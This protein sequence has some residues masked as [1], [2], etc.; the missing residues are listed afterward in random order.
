[1]KFVPFVLAI[2]MVFQPMTVIAAA[3]PNRLDEAISSL[4]LTANQVSWDLRQIQDFQQD[5]FRFP[6]FDQ[7][8]SKPLELPREANSTLSRFESCQNIRDLVVMAARR[9]AHE[10]ARWPMGPVPEINEKEPLLSS[11]EELYQS[12]GWRLSAKSREELKKQCDSLSPAWQ[13]QLAEFIGYTRQAE[14]YRNLAIRNIKP[15]QLETIFAQTPIILGETKGWPIEAYDAGLAFD[16]SFMYY[17]AAQ[18]SLA[19]DSAIALL[20]KEKPSL[21]EVDTPLGRI[22][23]SGGGDDRHDCQKQLLLLD[24]GGNDSYTGWVAGN[25]GLENPVSVAIDLSGNDT[26][27]TNYNFHNSMGSGRFGFACLYDA[28]GDDNYNAIECSQ[29]AA[30]FGVGVLIDKKGNDHY[31]SINLSQGAAEFGLGILQ[32]QEGTDVYESYFASQGFGFTQGIG[33]LQ[34]KSGNDTY[35]ANDTDIINSSAQSKEHNTSMCQGAGYGLRAEFDNGHS[36]SGG[37]GVLQ[38][39]GGDDS[40]SCGVFGQG[41][42][43]WHGMGILSDYAG[44]DNYKGTWYVQ[45]SCAHFG[46]AYFQERAGNDT[47]QATMATSIGVGH[48]TSVGINV[49][50]GGNDIYNCF[51]ME[52]GKKVYAGLVA[53]CGN[54][55]GI[56]IL[57]N[58]GGDDTYDIGATPSLGQYG[59]PMPCNGGT[60]RDTMINIGIFL[61]I[62]GNDTYTA[63]HA[64]E[65]TKWIQEPPKDCPDRKTDFG[66]GIDAKDGTIKPLF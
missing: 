40:Y 21:F 32:D 33:L 17:G 49:D 13:K 36:M 16:A 20:D 29:G 63:K 4:G 2:I 24:V 30:S 48:D 3:E 44:N 22:T 18:I 19:V 25:N 8:H 27:K 66:V 59:G 52:D 45:G 14:E 46:L 35:I 43:Y 1:M 58:I 55:N 9:S 51:R 50:L 60:I 64:K 54:N 42:A 5:P 10:V 38:D 65:N 26:Y 37:V 47:Y 12:R 62:G 39:M 11:L 41:V 56:G 15:E 53:G 6:W 61:D 57:A 23:I 7:L 34:D 28:E 31:S